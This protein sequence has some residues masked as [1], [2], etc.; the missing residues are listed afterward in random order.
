MK[1]NQ[2]CS[3]SEDLLDS[4]DLQKNVPEKPFFCLS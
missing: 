1:E 2:N 4:R 3:F